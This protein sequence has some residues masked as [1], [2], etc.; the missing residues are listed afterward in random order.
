MMSPT[1]SRRRAGAGRTWPRTAGSPTGRGLGALL[2]RGGRT[3]P[4]ARGGGPGESVRATAALA[5]SPR[6][7]SGCRHVLPR[8]FIRRSA[9]DVSLYVPDELHLVAAQLHYRHVDQAEDYQVV[10]LEPHAG[11]Y[12]AS[13]PA[14]YTASSYALQYFF[15]LRLRTHGTQLYPGFDS[16][17]TDQPYFV[18]AADRN[19]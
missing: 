7:G 10:Q 15:Q 16:E 19:S 1:R 12:R 2:H 6:G 18:V 9:L 3:E 5:A 4:A 11:E 17:R 8:H 14:S 13:I